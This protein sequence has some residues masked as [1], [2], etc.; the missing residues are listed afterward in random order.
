MV[1]TIITLWFLLH[2]G[3]VALLIGKKLKKSGDL[4]HKVTELT[5]NR[6]QIRTRHAT[7]TPILRP[8]SVVH[9]GNRLE[10]GQCFMATFMPN[11]LPTQF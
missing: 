11:V 10:I 3:V 5:Q 8:A 4:Y 7:R 1:C 2:Q 9:I 6:G